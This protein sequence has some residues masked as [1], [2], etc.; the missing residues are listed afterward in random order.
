LVEASFSRHHHA[1]VDVV[2]FLEGAVH[3]HL[4][5]IERS[6]VCASCEIAEM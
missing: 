2:A 1:A 6:V 4:P 3:F 5:I